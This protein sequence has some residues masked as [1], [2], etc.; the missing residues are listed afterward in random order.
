MTVAVDE[1]MVREF[2]TIV[3]EPVALAA[4]AG[5]PGVLQ[6]SRLNSHDEKLVPSRF[7]LDDLEAIV[8][9]AVF[10]A[11]AGQNVYIE[12]RSVRSDLRGPTRG[13]LSDT[14]WAFAVV[15]DADH[16][17]GKGCTITVRPTLVVETSPGNFHY[18]YFFD[19]PLS[20]KQAKMI[21]DTIRL[22]PTPASGARNSSARSRPMQ[23]ATRLGE[24]ALGHR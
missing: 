19:R 1:G 9:A 20:A 24:F 16:D 13:G 5:K 12:S 3:S 4:A 14:E 8:K 17:K 21:G 18:W 6:L 22:T 7:R 10:D 23:Y 2:V 15:I 11:N